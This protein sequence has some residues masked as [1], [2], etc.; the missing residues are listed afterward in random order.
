MTSPPS[1]G[2][3]QVDDRRFDELS[4]R[5]GVLAQPSR[6]RRTLLSLLG[7]AALTGALGLTLPGSELAEAKKNNHKKKKKKCKKNDQDCQCKKNPNK[8]NS[9]CKTGT[10]FSFTIGSSGSGSGQFN[11]PW[12]VATD[13]SNNI[14]VTDTNNQRVEVFDS[15][16]NFVRA[17]GSNGNGDEQ[18]KEPRGIGVNKE[19]S[20][21]NTSNLRVYVADPGQPNTDKRLRKYNTN[22][23]FQDD[24]GRSDL[25]TPRDIAIDSNNN[26]WVVDASATG[27]VFLFDNRGNFRAIFSPSGSGALA[28]PVGIGVFDDNNGNGDTFVYVADT[29]NNRVVKFRYD[30]NN[31]DGLTFITS[32]GS[33]GSGSNR[34]NEPSGVAVDKC[35]NVWV[36]DRL[37]DRVQLLDKDLNFKNT[38]TSGFNRPT[39][40]A[41]TTSNSSGLYVVDSG[42]NQ[43]QKFTL[44]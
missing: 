30:N 31:T 40:V 12:G 13:P 10:S 18:F 7:G 15:N 9:K 16:G 42:N 41:L 32:A 35:G 33:T 3:S 8:C 25:G 27:E 20:S 11:A 17:F 24:L 26:V 44:S 34:F 19:G 38:L 36:A 39:D 28:N 22:G 21:N 6:S 14:Y 2:G 1:Q 4:R 37:N 29:G 43:V 23:N 5:V